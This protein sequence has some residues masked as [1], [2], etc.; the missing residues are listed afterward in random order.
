MEIAMDFIHDHKA[1][2]GGSAHTSGTK[3]NYDRNEWLT[4]F[5]RPEYSNE[6]L[7]LVLPL[8]KVVLHND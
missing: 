4:T 2:W 6:R 3:S 7:E 5:T 1:S 8:E